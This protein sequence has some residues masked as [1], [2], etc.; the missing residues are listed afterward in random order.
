[1]WSDTV[2]RFAVLSAVLLLVGAIAAP[3]CGPWL[4]PARAQSGGGPG[5]PSQ[6]QPAP[7]GERGEDRAAIRAALDSFA[8]AFE[9]RDPKALAAHWTSGGE[10]HPLAGPMVQ[11]RESLEKGFTAFFARNPELKATIHHEALRF[12]SDDTAVEEGTVDIRRGPLEPASNARYTALMARE[13]G[14]WRVAQLSEAPGQEESIEDLGWLVGAW[15]S[16]GKQG[17]EIETTYAWQPN[18]KFLQA[19][20]TIKEKDL[21]LSGTQIIGVDPATGAIRSWTFEA[22]GG[23]ARGTGSSTATT[24]WSTPRAPCRTAGP[25]R[26]PTS[27]AAWTPTHSRGSRSSAVSETRRSTTSPP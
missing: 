15:K 12:L 20:F 10:Y 22:D 25:S 6:T 13:G 5:A 3:D 9:T 27:C 21:T 4:R 7:A 24:G 14:R 16:K 26:R 19:Q 1:M 11:G 17:A 2:R 18:K 8:K 23:S